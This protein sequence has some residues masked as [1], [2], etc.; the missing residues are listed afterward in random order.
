MKDSSPFHQN[1]A[2]WLIVLVP[3]LA[4]IVGIGMLFVSIY[5]FDGL[6]VDDYY[7]KG[8]E[9]NVTLERD[10]FAAKYEL[11]ADI[12]LDQANSAVLMELSARQDFRLP[13]KVYLQFLHRTLSGKDLL[14]ELHH[15]SG[16][17]YRGE[18]PELSES[19]WLIE[20]GTDDWRLTG[21]VIWPVEESFELESQRIS[22]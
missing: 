4:I 19:R 12:D 16:L 1:P 3:V 2:L 11:F 9:I 5:N 22:G 13:E 10:N 18:L 14:I 6:V 7:K 17:L 20:L 21:G 8:K 15:Q